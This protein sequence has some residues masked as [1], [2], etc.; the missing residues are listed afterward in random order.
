VLILNPFYTPKAPPL[1]NETLLI[2]FFQN[3]TYPEGKDNGFRQFGTTSGFE[4]SDSAIIANVQSSEIMKFSFLVFIQASQFFMDSSFSP[5]G[6]NISGSVTVRSVFDDVSSSVLCDQATFKTISLYLLPRLFWAKLTVS[7]LFCPP[8]FLNGISLNLLAN[9]HVTNAVGNL[10]LTVVSPSFRVH[11][12]GT[13]SIYFIRYPST[14]VMASRIYDDALEFR[15]YYGTALDNVCHQ[16]GIG[17]FK[18]SVELVCAGVKSFFRSPLPYIGAFLESTQCLQ[19]ITGISFVRPA[20]NCQFQVSVLTDVIVLQSSRDFEVVPGLAERGV[21]VGDGPFC[22]SAG[23]IVWSINSSSDGLCLVAQLQDA[24]GNNITSAV[25]AKVVARN[26]NDLESHYEVAQNASNISSSSGLIRWCNAYSSKSQNSGVVFGSSVNGNITYWTSSIINVS[27]TGHPFYLLP[28]TPDAV[29]SKISLPQGLSPPT[30]SFLAQDAGGNFLAGYGRVA[31]RV[32]IVPNA[33]MGRT[34]ASMS[35]FARESS[36]NLLQSSSFSSATC[37]QDTLLEFVFL[38]N[39]SN[40][41]IVAGPEFLCRTGE[42]DVFF[43]IGTYDADVFS[44]TALNAFQMS[45][46]VIPGVFKSFIIV[47]SF[48]IIA[49]QSYA[50]ID[51]LEIM[52]LD[53]GL[54]EVSGNATMSF[55]S[56][57]ASVFVYPAQPFMVESN[58]TFK[59]Y[60][61]PFFIYANHWMPTGSSN[62]IGITT[63][64]CSI[65]HYGSKILTVIM[66][67]T[68]APGHRLA[69]SFIVDLF[70]QSKMSK[71]DLNGT[72]MTAISKCVKC[73][74][75]TISNTFD[76]QTCRSV[77]I[78]FFG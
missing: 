20:K 8:K 42:N 23:A 12:S 11:S 41:Q 14:Q 5:I 35:R 46:T 2:R 62:L 19:N 15:F 13:T 37:D 29:K 65:P 31:V 61:P 17:T 6:T 78:C 48:R 53:I 1:T 64:N 58:E 70:V 72:A 4:W 54:N 49:T 40:H 7:L 47:E 21:L 77:C 75:G 30:L 10:S 55:I 60:A 68:C 24:E 38:Q 33:T 25:N 71:Q 59:S 56:V 74:N 22:A 27:L 50:L 3:L 32:R 67:W 39:S 43:D 16:G 76:S 69:T 57:N 9:L 45:I 34:V 73:V 18:Y 66:N 52:F 36:R 44:P 28:A 63:A 26:V 51:F